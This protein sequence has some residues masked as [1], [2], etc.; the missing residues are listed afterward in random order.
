MSQEVII[1]GYLSYPHLF[2]PRQVTNAQGVTS[3]DPKFSANVIALPGFDW[4]PVQAAIALATN[5]WNLKNPQKP[6]PQG[7]RMPLEQ[8]TEGPYTGSWQLKASSS[9]DRRPQ[10]VG[11]NPQIP[12]SPQEISAIFPGCLVNMWVRIY[13]YGVMD[14]GITA[15]FNGLQIV[16]TAADLPRLDN[17][18]N[19]AE[20]FQVIA[21]APPATAGQ[22]MQP[23]QPAQQP[24]TMQPPQTM[25]PA[26]Q[27]AM[28]PMQP[29]TQP[30]TQP[31][32]PG[33]MQPAMQPV[34]APAAAVQ[35]GA[36]A[37]AL[38]WAQ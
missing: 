35:P 5:E 10:I 11:L 24:V 32:Q 2:T 28:Q 29:A 3:G 17:S 36:P 25:Q 8:V 13:G 1:Q 4:G 22:P 18:R 37:G 38:P 31:V 19:A 9:Q 16:S 14:V 33:Q 12:I 26:T 6:V 23:M 27:P 20:V 34:A 30:A 21:G 7:A 15:A